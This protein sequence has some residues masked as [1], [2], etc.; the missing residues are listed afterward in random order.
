MDLEIDSANPA[1]KA[2]I[3]G[4]APRPAQLAAARG[5]LPLP[6]NDLLEVLVALTKSDDAEL[7]QNAQS[8]LAAQDP[9][10]LQNLGDRIGDDCCDRRF[11]VGE[12]VDKRGVGAVFQQP[13]HQISQQFL[14]AADRR[15]DA[16]W[17]RSYDLRI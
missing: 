7:A 12:T 9:L 1:V 2:I 10:E 17:L 5:I 3:T 15:V 14:V 6:Q 11:V 8:T 13:P 16:G 4:T